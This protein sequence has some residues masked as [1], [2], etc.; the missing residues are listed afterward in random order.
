M[1]GYTEDLNQLEDPEGIYR[2]FKPT[3]ELM[4]YTKDL[5]QLKE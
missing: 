5:N 3:G 2:G 1:K 4:G